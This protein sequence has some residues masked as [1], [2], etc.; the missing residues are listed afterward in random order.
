MIIIIIM[1][2]NIRISR[3]ILTNVKLHFITLLSAAK[4]NGYLFS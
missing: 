1:M 4:E 2:K 3:K